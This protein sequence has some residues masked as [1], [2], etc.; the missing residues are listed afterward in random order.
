MI[1]DNT[2]LTRHQIQL[3]LQ[4][5][6]RTVRLPLSNVIFSQWIRQIYSITQCTCSFAIWPDL[7]KC[8]L[9]EVHEWKPFYFF[10]SNASLSVPNRYTSIVQKPRLNVFS[11]LQIVNN[12]LCLP[13]VRSHTQHIRGQDGTQYI[14]ERTC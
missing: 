3:C 2:G 7:I 1:V 5:L 8:S 10:H 11:E 14:W 6:I 12:L 4:H 9:F 13:K